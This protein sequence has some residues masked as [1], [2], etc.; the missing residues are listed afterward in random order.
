MADEAVGAVQHVAA[1][2]VHHQRRNILEK[3]RKEKK[4][5]RFPHSQRTL[6]EV[7]DD[8]KQTLWRQETLFSEQNVIGRYV[9][10][11]QRLAER[12][13]ASVPGMQYEG[14]RR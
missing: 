9:A 4:E 13:S 12:Y 10:S 6:L 8:L 14:R 11:V 7:V 1:R 2:Q 3:K 5:A